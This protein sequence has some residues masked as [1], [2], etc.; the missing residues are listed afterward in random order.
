VATRSDP[1][2]HAVLF[3]HAFVARSKRKEAAH[4]AEFK[5]PVLV[6]GTDPFA[7]ENRNSAHYARTTAL[8]FADQPKQAITR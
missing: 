6:A 2:S 4:A 7:W 8:P 5:D 3:E 1:T